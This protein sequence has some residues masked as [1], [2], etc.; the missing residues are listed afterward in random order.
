MRRFGWLMG[1]WVI[2]CV[3]LSPGVHAV[4]GEAGSTPVK[5][6]RITGKEALKKAYAV[7]RLSFNTEGDEKRSR[8]LDAIEAYKSILTSHADDP[9][10]ASTAALRAADLCRGIKKT[11]EAY[12]LYESVLQYSGIK[13]NGA[14]ALSE[15]AHIQRRASRLDDAL[16]LFRQVGDRFPDESS[17]VSKG[18]M[19]IGKIH[20]QRREIDLARKAWRE[21]M[22][23]C[24]DPKKTLVQ[25]Y[26]LLGQSFLQTNEISEARL[27]VDE[28]RKRFDSC[29][30]SDKKKDK[31]VARAIEKMK[32]ATRLKEL[33]KNDPETLPEKSG[34]I[35]PGP[36]KA[37]GPSTGPPKK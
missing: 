13:K 28:C 17:E 18:L 8:I 3:F 26:D 31:D 16:E 24:E 14:R 22:T 36:P 4:E 23:R 6:E 30:E 7:R 15:M 25:I 35:Q 1:V 5:K 29:F 11:D 19:W 20:E 32:S 27:T 12:R 34:L 37:P 2:V 33:T 10:T 21:A 9:A